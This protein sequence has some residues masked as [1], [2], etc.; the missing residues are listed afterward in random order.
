M[1]SSNRRDIIVLVADSNM[2]AAVCGLLSR[3]EALGIRTIDAQILS[4]NV[5][6]KHWRQPSTTAVHRDL[7]LSTV[8]L[9]R[10]YR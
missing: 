2:E 9:R 3:H 7:R 8:T 1:K 5:P 4:R 6:K 10:R